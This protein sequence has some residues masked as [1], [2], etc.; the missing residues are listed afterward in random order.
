[1][2]EAIDTLAPKTKP[3]HRRAGKASSHQGSQAPDTK[4]WDHLKRPVEGDAERRFDWPAPSIH[5]RAL[6]E[7]MD[8]ARIPYAVRMKEARAQ[9][10][11][12]R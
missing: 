3:S 5:H 2:V 1:M 9:A 6:G 4:S 11:A 7:T 10:R 8:E 12:K